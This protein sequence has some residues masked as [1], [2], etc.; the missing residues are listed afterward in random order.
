MSSPQREQPLSALSVWLANTTSHSL[1]L[2]RMK[3]DYRYPGIKD[4]SLPGDTLPLVLTLVNIT[5]TCSTYGAA[6]LLMCAFGQWAEYLVKSRTQNFNRW[7]RWGWSGRVSCAERARVTVTVFKLAW[8]TVVHAH[9]CTHTEW[10]HYQLREGASDAGAWEKLA[11]LIHKTVK[12]PGRKAVN[13]RNQCINILGS[14]WNI[15]AGK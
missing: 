13:K 4:T 12:F 15:S 8:C 2:T 1:L 5:V 11:F 9:T 7:R 6:G 3:T 10:C 14:I